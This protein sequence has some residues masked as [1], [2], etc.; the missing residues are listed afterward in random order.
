MG[1]AIASAIIV[2][3]RLAR[4]DLG[5]PSPKIAAA[6]PQSVNLAKAVLESVFLTPLPVFS[7]RL[8]GREVS[9]PMPSSKKPQFPPFTYPELKQAGEPKCPICRENGATFGRGMVS[10]NAIGPHGTQVEMFQGFC[11][12]CTNF[13]I[14]R[15][16]VDDARAKN[17]TYLLSA[18]LRDLPDREWSE[19]FEG[20]IDLHSWEDLV[21]TIIQPDI[22]GLTDDALVIICR[23]CPD[24]GLSSRFDYMVDW[25]LL[26]VKSPNAALFV[27]NALFEGGFLQAA[28]GQPGPH[29]PLTPTWKAYER[30]KQLES[31][32]RSS[33]RAFVAMS[34]D[35]KQDAVYTQV[36]QPAI[37]AAGYFP[38]RVDRVTHNEKIDDFIISEIRRCRFVVADFTD[39]KTGVYFEAGFGYGLGRRVIWMCHKSETHLLH[40]DTRQFFHILYDDFDKARED[41]T[42][43]IEALEGHGSYVEATP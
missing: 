21:S 28:R 22:V 37:V 19:L 23:S 2:A 34:F 24:I 43:R 32:G 10:L 20:P 17:K 42:N 41:L 15:E 12:A 14:T 30:L 6:I 16:A 33:E 38:V 31:S 7:F 11:Q 26:R 4:E 25:P 9:A 8:N 3:V 1:T 36:I 13:W 40:F 5:R 35:P 18:Y 29:Y 39:Q 27:V